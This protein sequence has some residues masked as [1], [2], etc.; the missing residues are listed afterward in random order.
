M[1][2]RKLDL[3]QG[4]LELQLSGFGLRCRIVTSPISLHTLTGVKTHQTSAFVAAQQNTVGY[5]VDQELQ[6]ILQNI[7]LSTLNI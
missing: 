1:S 3:F 4:R 2:L 7:S 5:S 6:Y